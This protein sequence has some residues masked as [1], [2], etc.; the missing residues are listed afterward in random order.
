MPS[1]GARS[2][3]YTHT[4]SHACTE[5]TPTRT[6][7]HAHSR[8]V[9]M[10]THSRTRRRSRSSQEVPHRDQLPPL[11]PRPAV[12]TTGPSPAQC[13]PGGPR[14]RV[15]TLGLPWAP[16]VTGA[17]GLV[18]LEPAPSSRDGVKQGHPL[19]ILETGISSG[20]R[21]LPR[22]GWVMRPRDRPLLRPTQTSTR[23]QDPA[24][25]APGHPCAPAPRQ[26]AKRG[27]PAGAAWGVG[28]TPQVPPYEYLKLC[29]PRTENSGSTGKSSPNLPEFLEMQ[30]PPHPQPQGGSA[31]GHYGQKEPPPD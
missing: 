3:T 1:G 18:P 21:Y 14:R 5:L 11:H 9:H 25:A 24:S 27:S 4:R 6:L 23:R 26:V 20:Q 30:R 16:R 13:P 2:H 31:L 10:Q 7:E 29:L 19:E 22:S 15:W 12:A 8:D 28:A 17:V